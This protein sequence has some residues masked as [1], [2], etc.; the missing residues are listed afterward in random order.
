[1]TSP[2]GSRSRDYRVSISALPQGHFTDDDASVHADA[3]DAAA[4][5]GIVA[6]CNPPEADLFCPDRAVT[7]AEM[8]TF[9]VRAVD[10]APAQRPAGF[11][12]VDPQGVHADAID[13]LYAAGTT[14][15]CFA[16][17]RRY[18]GDRPVTR[19]EMAAFLARAL[20]LPAP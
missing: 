15:G 13:A 12:D 11:V 8:A 2:D 17:P 20:D 19:A 3:I 1:M 4:T 14:K 9:L 16:R 5:A 6:G 10:L 18:C 7:R